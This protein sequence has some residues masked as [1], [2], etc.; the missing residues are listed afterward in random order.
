MKKLFAICLMLVLAVSTLMAKE[1]D[2]SLKSYSI[3]GRPPDELV[4]IITMLIGEEGKIVRDRG[5]NRLL[6]L[7]TADEHK[8][9]SGIMKQFDIIPQNVRVQVMI[10]ETAKQIKTEAGGNF[11]VTKQGPHYKFKFDPRAT[12]RATTKINCTTQSLLVSSGR[13]ASLRIGKD[14]PGIKWIVEYSQHR[15]LLIIQEDQEVKFVGARLKVKPIV[16]DKG[17]YIYI[18]LTPEVSA[19][20]DGNLRVI[21]YTELTTEVTAKN[22]EPLEIASFGRNQAFYDKF[23]SGFSSSGESETVA[24]TLLPSIVYPFNK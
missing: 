3:H 4:E 15:G 6:V 2:R 20:V 8:K 11:H 24:V 19:L 10:R 16:I 22:N 13:E 12:A 1:T 23:L 9:I 5:L 14:I 18:K 7:A 17:P 21:E